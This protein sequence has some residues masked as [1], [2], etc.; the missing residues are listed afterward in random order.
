MTIIR[1][2]AAV[3]AGLIF[4]FITHSGMDFI[5]E[6]LGIFMSPHENFH[7]TWMVVTAFIYRTL[8]SI[9]G[10]YLT[11]RL[12]PSRPMTHALAL[13]TIGL[14]F[15]TVAATV[16]IPMNISPTWYPIALALVAVPSGWLGG[17]LAEKAI[18][19]PQLA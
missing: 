5:L 16:L 8:L 3:L 2:I 12:A 11:A 4:I 18:P 19:K 17:K 9:A 14:I 15:C 6:S 7:T 13:G 1:S 10:G